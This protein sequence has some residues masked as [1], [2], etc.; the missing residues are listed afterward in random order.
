MRSGYDGND[1]AR[2]LDS[3]N[4]DALR[5]AADAADF[6]CVHANYRSAVG[7][8]HY[9]VR[10]IDHLEAH[11]LARLFVEHA[12]FYAFARASLASVFVRGGTFAVAAGGHR[13]NFHSVL[14]EGHI[15]NVVAVVKF[16]GFDALRVASHGSYVFFGK[17][18]ALAVA[19]SH[20]KFVVA[21]GDDCRDKLVVVQ[22]FDG[23]FACAANVDE[24][25]EAGL[26]DKSVSGGQ[27]Q[28][29]VVIHVVFDDREQSGYLFSLLELQ[30]VDDGSASAHT[31]GFRHF[32]AFQAVNLAHI[33][34]EHKIVVRGRGEHGFHE[35]VFFGLV[36]G[37][38]HAASVLTLIFRNRHTF[39]VAAVGESYD[40]VF[41]FDEVFDVDFA[42]VVADFRQTRR[43]VA[44]FYIQHFGFDDF[45]HAAD[46][47]QNV[48]IICYF[49][50][51]ILKFCVYLVNF[52]RGEAIDS[53]FQ[54]GVC[55]RV[56]EE[57]AFDKFCL[58]VHSV[59]SGFDDL[60]NFVD[61][62]F[63]DGQAL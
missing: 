38:A 21:L 9:V 20:D 14:N 39:Y 45:V 49:A 55:L 37:N 43:V 13:Q 33:R 29:A 32:V 35:V 11:Q 50:L 44:R 63:G 3:H 16:Y 10:R 57:E 52:Q 36:R 48:L 53:H 25:G 28:E 31:R 27:H 61:V 18:Y 5:V 7:D 8:H 51:F 41:F 46:I 22:K 54:N 47:C 4:S 12:C 60:D 59:G 6:F 34:E 30:Q 2:A 40:D 19:G 56:A 24:F 58:R 42:V 15:H 23:L 26:F 1:F 17:P 62:G